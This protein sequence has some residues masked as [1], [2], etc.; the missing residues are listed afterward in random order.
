MEFTVD[1]IINAFTPA[2]KRALEIIVDQEVRQVLNR[3]LQATK[4]DIL[5]IIETKVIELERRQ[6]SVV[7]TG[8]PIIEPRPEFP[9][10]TEI[11]RLEVQYFDNTKLKDKPKTIANHKLKVYT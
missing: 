9:Q 3:A 2:Q 6:D 11:T 1:D 5:D 4:N 7:L 8:K 10:I